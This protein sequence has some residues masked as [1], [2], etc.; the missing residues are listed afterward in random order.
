MLVQTSLAI[1]GTVSEEEEDGWVRY[2]SA[3]NG[4]LG[5]DMEEERQMLQADGRS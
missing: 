4:D 2:G 3:K 1:E 5:K